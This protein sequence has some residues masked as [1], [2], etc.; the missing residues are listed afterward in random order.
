MLLPPDFLGF[1]YNIKID[2][3]E[4]NSWIEN[5]ADI[6]GIMLSKPESLNQDTLSKIIQEIKWFW[7]FENEGGQQFK[8]R[9]SSHLLDLYKFYPEFTIMYVIPLFK[10]RD[11]FA[12]KCWEALAQ[13]KD[14]IPQELFLY[15]KDVFLRIF[16]PKKLND[17]VVSYYVRKLVKI[18]ISNFSGDT[19]YCNIKFGNS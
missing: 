11:K 8:V 5:L 10:F 4:T 1:N 6:F 3:Y 2:D 13:N 19:T 9:M 7:K 14:F 15:L 16:E 12:D 18:A 17:P